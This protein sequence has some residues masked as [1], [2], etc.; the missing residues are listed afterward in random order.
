MQ[1]KLLA[2]ALRGMLLLSP[3][4]ATNLLKASSCLFK[5]VL[6]FVL[7]VLVFGFGFVCLCLFLVLVFAF[8]FVF[9]L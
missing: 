7:F 1:Q 2:R 9:C 6:L 8:C 4:I 5:A 3:P